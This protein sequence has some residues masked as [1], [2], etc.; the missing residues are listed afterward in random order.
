MLPHLCRMVLVD[1]HAHLYLDAFD[2]DRDEMIARAF[3]AGVAYLLLPNI[4][5]S[6][7]NGMHQLAS[8]YSGKVFPMM[9][10][11][12][13][14]V[15]EDYPEVLL[16][17]RA[18]L[19]Q[20]KYVAVGETGID[21]YWDKTTLTIQEEAFRIQ[22]EWAKELELP[23]VIHARDSYNEL[24]R[25]LD[26]VH[27][28]RLKGVFHCFTGSS[29]QARK[30]IGYETFMMGI[31][32]VLTYPK[33]GLQETVKSIPVEFLVL[34]TDSPFLTPVPHRGKRNESSYIPLILQVLSQALSLSEEKL[35][36]ITT[37]NAL[38]MFDRINE[39]ITQ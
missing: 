14:D 29:D 18:L 39:T 12:P 21:L 38:R 10:L 17:M 26:E 33:A 15:G 35:A 30:I 1:T 19:D 20:E 27:D 22:V 11:H 16:R 24:F 28:E 8:A 9:G 7:I 3:S 25:I 32:G 2:E 13:C 5:E 34:E 4:S 37:A 6:S 36:S 23:L 31:G